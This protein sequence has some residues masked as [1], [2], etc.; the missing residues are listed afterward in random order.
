LIVLFFNDD[1]DEGVKNEAVV[2]SRRMSRATWLAL[3]VGGGAMLDLDVAVDMDDERGG[4][5][6]LER[7]DGEVEDV[8]D[9]DVAGRF[10][11][12]A[13]GVGSG[14]RREFERYISMGELVSIRVSSGVNMDI[15]GRLTTS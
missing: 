3:G 9:P 13:S 10:G 14:C 6:G 5:L 8:D 12:T 2:S 15:D 7:I 4:V 1:G 11:F